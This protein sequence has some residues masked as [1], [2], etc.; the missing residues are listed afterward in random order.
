MDWRNL[1]AEAS[2]RWQLLK[3]G[4]KIL[5]VLLGLG[6]II[7]LI[8]F[9]SL[10]TRPAYAPLFTG[11]DPA[12]AG[13]LVE[14]LKKMNVPYRLTDQGKTIEVPA[15]QVYETRIQL[16]SSG[17]LGEGKGFELFD[18][19]KLGVTDFEQQVQYQRALQEELRRTIVQLE[20]V[21]QARVHLVLP[22]KSVFVEEESPSSA[23]IVLK[24]KPFAQ[25]KP[26][27]IKG[28]VQLAVGSVEGLKPENVHIIDTK[29]NVLNADLAFDEQAMLTQGALKQYQVKKAYEKELEKRIQ[30]ML[31]RIFG[32]GKAV[33][34]VT[35]DLDFDR[36]EVNTVTPQPGPVVSEQTI[37]ESGTAPQ[38]GGLPGT[39]GNLPGYPAQVAPAGEGYSRNETIRNYQPGSR[40]EKVIS[41]PGKLR[42]LSV[43]V[44]VDAPVSPGVEQQVAEVV[45]AATGLNPARGDQLSVSTLAFD[46]TYQQE[47]EAEMARQEAEKKRAQ[48]QKLFS[49]AIAAGALILFVLAVIM[50]RALR[51]RAERGAAPEV[52][53]LKPVGELE[54]AAAAKEEE[55]VGPPSLEEQVKSLARQRPAEVADIIKVW[56]T[57]S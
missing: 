20:E 36:Q 49:A 28:M 57:E 6:T 47:I 45:G 17:A 18:Q 46:K 15:K 48:Q 21:E 7:S 14:K 27:Q 35:A 1:P 41:A 50:I 10:I 43:A 22:Q 2:K 4:Q 52:E 9:V 54:E 42:R 25:L 12:E 55:V 37:T 30:Q 31:E 3:P 38:A 44:A 40:Q 24:L 39:T 34:M 13:A 56:M 19:T 51:R 8:F 29:G 26:E 23:S 16:A 11:L 5:A 53:E 33:A 32:P